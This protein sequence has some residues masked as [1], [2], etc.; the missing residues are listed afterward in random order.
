[1]RDA[2]RETRREH[3]IRFVLNYGDLVLS[4]TRPL[5][6]RIVRDVEAKQYEPSDFARN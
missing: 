3:H 4:A 2:G 5:L 1:M 6:L